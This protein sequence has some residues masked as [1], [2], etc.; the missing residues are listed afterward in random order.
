MDID[1]KNYLAENYC[2]ELVLGVAKTILV[3]Q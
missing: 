3:I 2:F 1:H